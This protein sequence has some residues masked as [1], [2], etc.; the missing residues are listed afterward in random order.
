[1]TPT[2]EVEGALWG[3]CGLEPKGD[4]GWGVEQ[5]SQDTVASFC[6]GETLE[7]V[8]VYNDQSSPSHLYKMSV[9]KILSLK[10]TPTG[11]RGEQANRLMFTV[12]NGKLRPTPDQAA[13]KGPPLLCPS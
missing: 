12:L 3:R 13:C 6:P 11:P 2:I 4:L 8:L 5:R 1:M 9:C 7:Q 10:T